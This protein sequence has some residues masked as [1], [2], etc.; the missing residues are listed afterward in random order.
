M[1]LETVAMLMR[2]EEHFDI[3]VPDEVAF[4]CLTVAD[5]QRVI[6]ELLVAKNRQFSEAQVYSD[7]VKIIVDETGIPVTD[8]RPSSR[9]V[10]DITR[11]G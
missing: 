6:I 2:V 8:I 9:W 7:L 10:G 3:S 4:K 5:L 1:G 11:Y